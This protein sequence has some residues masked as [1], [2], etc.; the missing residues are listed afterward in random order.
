[1]ANRLAEVIKFFLTMLES[2]KKDWEC[3]KNPDKLTNIRTTGNSFELLA[4]C[5]FLSIITVILDE[6]S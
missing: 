6:F 5:L 4:N 3:V 2:A 1:M